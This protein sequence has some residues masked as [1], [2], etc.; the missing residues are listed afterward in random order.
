MR[1]RNR[2]GE[3]HNVRKR[4]YQYV[5]PVGNSFFANWVSGVS[6]NGLNNDQNAYSRDGIDH[7]EGGPRASPMVLRNDLQRNSERSPA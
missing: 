7:V 1:R 6:T 4:M 2:E 3:A 5:K